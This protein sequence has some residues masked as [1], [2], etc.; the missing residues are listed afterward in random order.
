M[1][2]KDLLNLANY[3]EFDAKRECTELPKGL[4][5]TATNPSEFR[6]GDIIRYIEGEMK[7]FKF[8]EN[9]SKGIL[10][11]KFKMANADIYRREPMSMVSEAEAIAILNRVNW[12]KQYYEVRKKLETGRIS[13][14]EI[15][16]FMKSV[17]RYQR[18]YSGGIIKW[19]DVN[20]FIN[21]YFNKFN[22][23]NP[24][25]T[26]SYEELNPI[27]RYTWNDYISEKDAVTKLISTVIPISIKIHRD[28]DGV[29]D[30]K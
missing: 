29:I 3:V 12:P 30:R 8:G 13:Y 26:V 10:L 9:T 20:E 7:D 28:M 5:T 6:I 23:E 27:T 2:F 17:Q 15:D 14:E 19:G 25:Y 22:A 1:S 11:N 4:I 16:R 18:K 24:K 21:S